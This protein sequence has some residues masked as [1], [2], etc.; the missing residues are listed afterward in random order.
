[1]SL[2]RGAVSLQRVAVVRGQAVIGVAFSVGFTVG[3]MAGAALRSLD[4]RSVWPAGFP[5]PHPFA[6]AAVVATALAVA[7]ALVLTFGLPETHLPSK[8]VPAAA[9]DDARRAPGTGSPSV[10]RIVAINGAFISVFSGLEF[11]LAFLTAERFQYSPAKNGQLLAF[12]G[13]VS[14]AVQGGFLRRIT[15]PGQELRIA[16]YGMVALV[17]ACVG[18]AWATSTTALYVATV[19]FAFA[20]ATVVSC[21]TAAASF[22]APPGTIGTALG[23]MR[24]GGQLGRTL[25]PAAVAALYFAYGPTT[26]YL[27]G[28]GAVLLPIAATVASLPRPQQAGKKDA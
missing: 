11:S 19:F 17:I 1:M 22:A 10:G 14:A 21:L 23:H 9:G 3:P 20:S 15:R 28:A 4:V 8:A 13:V 16:V 6:G 18:L 7:S 5:P 2:T 26:A 12:I 27:A 25:G 24:A